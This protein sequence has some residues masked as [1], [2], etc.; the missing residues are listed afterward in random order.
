MHQRL[1]EVTELLETVATSRMKQKQ[2]T[3]DMVYAYYSID[4]VRDR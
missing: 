3:R 2:I 4:N 1:Y